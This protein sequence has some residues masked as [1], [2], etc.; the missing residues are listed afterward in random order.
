MALRNR[1]LIGFVVWL[2]ILIS[3][4]VTVLL[5]LSPGLKFNSIL[6]LSLLQR[7]TGLIAF[8]LIFLQI[9]T[10]SLLP[11]LVQVFGARVY[12]LHVTQGLFAY[13]FILLH[14]LMESAIVYSLS[15]EALD[16]FAAIFPKAGS[17]RDVYIN[18]GRISLVLATVT[19]VAAYFRTKPFF[20]RNWLLFHYLNYAVFYFFFYHAYKLGSDIKTLPF[21]LVFWPAPFI[22]GVTILYRFLPRIS[23]YL[24]KRGVLSNTKGGG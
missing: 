24:G 21:S 1:K 17:A 20:R 12:K 22:V 19:V 2:L 14:P 4:P 6:V 16:F 7:S 13:G 3:G 23:A 5:T 18:F 10:G 11:L 9:L 8:S 15:G